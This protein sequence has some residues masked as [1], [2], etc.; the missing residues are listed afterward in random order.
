MC[1]TVALG[2]APK[3]HLRSNPAEA[4]VYYQVP[5]STELKPLGSTPLDLQNSELKSKLG[6]DS[7]IGYAYELVFKKPGFS[8]ER[9]LVP[10]ERFGTFETTVAVKL[11]SSEQESRTA[12]TLLLFLFNAQKFANQGDFDRAQDEL[13]HAFELSPNFARA[14]SM[15]G[16]IYFLQHR[17]A[18]AA[19]W[20]ERALAADPRLDDAV[21]MIA[22]TNRHLKLRSGA[23]Q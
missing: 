6:L 2:C 9:V 10:V 18:E 8:T 11:Q 22:E 20:Y 3:L 23:A 16:T 5:N 21:K 19:K 13:G 4:R 14:L 12:D 1:F 17:Y 15:R 7:N